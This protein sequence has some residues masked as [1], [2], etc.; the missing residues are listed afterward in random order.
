MKSRFSHPQAKLSRHVSNILLTNMEDSLR[1]IV[2]KLDTDERYL[3]DLLKVNN[4]K[5]SNTYNISFSA[6]K[7]L[8]KLPFISKAI[9]HDLSLFYIQT[10]EEFFHK[11]EVGLLADEKIE[12]AIIRASSKALMSD[13]LSEEFTLLLEHDKLVWSNYFLEWT[14]GTINFISKSISSYSRFSAGLT[15]NQKILLFNECHGCNFIINYLIISIENLLKMKKCQQVIDIT[16]LA[17]TLNSDLNWLLIVILQKFPYEILN[18]FYESCFSSFTIR[19]INAPLTKELLLICLKNNHVHD[20]IVYR[21]FYE[22]IEALNSLFKSDKDNNYLHFIDQLI[23][24]LEFILDI[25]EFENT[26]VNKIFIF[27]MNNVNFR[28]LSIINR[29]NLD[30]NQMFNGFLDRIANLS[31][32]YCSN[33]YRIAEILFNSYTSNELSAN[34]VIKYIMNKYFDIMYDFALSWMISSDSKQLNQEGKLFN[35]NMLANFKS[36][37]SKINQFPEYSFRSCFVKLFLSIFLTCYDKTNQLDLLIDILSYDEYINNILTTFKEIINDYIIHNPLIIVNFIKHL[38]HRSKQFLINPIE[39][40]KVLRNFYH[41]IEM[42]MT[43]DIGQQR[44]FTMAITENFWIF[45]EWNMHLN[46][47]CLHEFL[48]IINN[49]IKNNQLKLILSNQSSSN[50]FFNRSSSSSIAY[51]I[52]NILRNIYQYNI[53]LADNESTSMIVDDPK[54]LGYFIKQTEIVEKLYVLMILNTDQNSIALVYSILMDELFS[55]YLLIDRSK[56]KDFLIPE[57]NYYQT[58][59]NGKEKTICLRSINEENFS[60]ETFLSTN[61]SLYGFTLLQLIRNISDNFSNKEIRNTIP[62]MVQQLGQHPY[63]ILLKCIQRSFLKQDFISYD[64]IVN[65][66]C[67]KNNTEKYLKLFNLFKN[68]PCLWILLTANTNGDNLNFCYLLIFNLFAAIIQQWDSENRDKKFLPNT[69]LNRMT[70]NILSLVSK[71]NWLPAPLNMIYE[72]IDILSENNYRNTYFLLSSIWNF[73]FNN[74]YNN[75]KHYDMKKDLA[76]VELTFTKDKF[77]D[78]IELL[79]TLLIDKIESTSEFYKKMFL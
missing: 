27:I 24:W 62:K 73:V 79:K 40:K 64:L 39:I 56:S 35:E 63:S 66:D 11:V 25:L 21:I 71:A 69:K 60:N 58:F 22:R 29:N 1:N 30:K 17:Y 41:I 77:A 67:F 72:I 18:S 33:N 16:L 2:S 49:L 6:V 23:K 75:L 42:E 14:F 12:K 20:E 54:A 46:K 68:F 38:Y 5:E 74:V 51:S 10:A 8:S 36:I 32:K 4:K 70:Y 45:V 37:I 13:P 19:D 61:E 65:E 43:L 3:L 76:S 52:L 31:L 9:S 53:Q 48:K 50:Q 28:W 55:N 26:L 59:L 34:E 44:Y 57:Y 7:L 15:T 78:A 47:D